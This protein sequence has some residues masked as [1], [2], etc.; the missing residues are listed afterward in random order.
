MNDVGAY[1]ADQIGRFTLPQLLCRSTDRAPGRGKF[2]SGEDLVR[3]AADRAREKAEA[4]ARWGDRR[5]SWR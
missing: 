2:A 1:T 5:P 4:E 3:F